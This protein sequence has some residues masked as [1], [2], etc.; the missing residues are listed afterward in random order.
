VKIK[1]KIILTIIMFILGGVFSL[2]LTA[3]LSEVL[4]HKTTALRFILPG[5]C[6]AKLAS[7]RQSL[8]MYLCFDGFFLMLG[9]LL[10]TTNT[11]PYR[12]D[13]VTVT[14]DIKI[15]AAVGQYQHGSAHFLTQKEKD[16]AFDSFVLDPLQRQVKYLLKTGY[17][18][19]DFMKDGNGKD[20]KPPD[21]APPPDSAPTTES[22]E[23]TS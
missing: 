20:T 18:D 3:S 10:I 2:F 5:E 11:K 8:M 14:P 17:E 21:A 1:T 6:I 7:D 4:S 15:P 16:K 23:Q 12:S 13:L 19:L 9:L 22:G